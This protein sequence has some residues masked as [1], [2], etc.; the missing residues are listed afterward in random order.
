[1]PQVNITTNWQDA[2][3]GWAPMGVGLPDNFL[4][5]DPALVNTTIAM[6][7]MQPVVWRYDQHSAGPNPEPN[8]D[9]LPQAV[10]ILALYAAGASV[11]LTKQQFRKIEGRVERYLD[12]VGD[13]D[14]MGT[15]NW[16]YVN[17][18]RNAAVEQAKRD[19]IIGRKTD[20]AP[21]GAT[22]DWDGEVGWEPMGEALPEQF[23]D[24]VGGLPALI[25]WFPSLFHTTVALMF[26]QP[27]PKKVEPL[28]QGVATLAI[29]ASGCAV[30]LSTQQFRKLER[31]AKLYI[32]HIEGQERF[33]GTKNGAYA[34][35]VRD[36][37]FER[38]KREMLI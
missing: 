31:A 18:V 30:T 37:A 29:Y 20:P 25:E 38:A 28:T 23:L 24:L 21:V 17:F 12:I 15:K 14:F 22:V 3:P 32:R 2:S 10:A 35:R 19:G 9:P 26:M 16:D 7:C 1:M 33:N 6:L 13:E 8:V 36:A 27:D 5:G 34:S 11:R 4:D